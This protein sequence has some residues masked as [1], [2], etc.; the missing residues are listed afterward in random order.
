MKLDWAGE[1]PA[2]PPRTT[3][4]AINFCRTLIRRV[5]AMVFPLTGDSWPLMI[6]LTKANAHGQPCHWVCR[7][8]LKNLLANLL[9]FTK[10][11]GQYC[12]QI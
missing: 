1:I 5:L 11:S 2:S 9:T 10:A 7:P 4:E 12:K 8:S 3:A 6:N